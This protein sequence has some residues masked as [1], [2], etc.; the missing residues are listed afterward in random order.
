MASFPADRCL[1]LSVTWRIDTAP[2]S[3]SE[4]LSGP[5]PKSSNWKRAMKRKDGSTTSL[6]LLKRVADWA[7]QPARRDFRVRYDP[8]IHSWC[9]GYG[10]DS[11]TLKDLCQP[12]SIELADRMRTHQYDPGRTFRGCRSRTTSNNASSRRP[13]KHSGGSPWTAALSARPRTR[14]GCRT[15]LP[16][17]RT[18]GWEGCSAS[19]ANVPSASVLVGGVK[20]SRPINRDAARSLQM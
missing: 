19:K 10:L 12:V 7:D 9:G 3:C 6:S 2:E 11:S 15:R 5:R 18:S 20:A 13:G 17:W 14:W 8:L 1:S 16:L 4:R